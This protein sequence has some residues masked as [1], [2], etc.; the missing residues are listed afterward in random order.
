MSNGAR[1]TWG[2]FLGLIL[3]AALAGLL[4]FG[5]YRLQHGFVMQGHKTD[6]WLGGG[7]LA[8]AAI[9]FA[10]LT[11][12]RISPLASLIGG[13][14]LTAAGVLFFVSQQTTADLINRFPFK[15]Q[16]VTLAGLEE[17][18]FIL[19]AG[20]GL[21]FG[22]FFPSRWRSRP[23]DDSDPAYEYGLPESEETDGRRSTSTGGRGR[24]AAA[25]DGGSTPAYGTP[26]HTDTHVYGSAD[27]G[28]IPVYGSAEGPAATAY[29]QTEFDVPLYEPERQYG[30]QSPFRPRDEDG[31]TREM[32]RPR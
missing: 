3:T 22:S 12:S 17:E 32:R 6:K 23:D 21:L 11:A 30:D 2:F 5:T 25:R 31:G 29:G 4:I 28:D 26:R 27:Q 14:I 10:L 24:H 18:G 7:A 13:L 8:G 16:R 9:V 15:G 20:V 1:H 19:F